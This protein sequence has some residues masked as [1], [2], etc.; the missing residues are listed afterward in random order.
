MSGT[1]LITIADLDRLIEEEADF[2]L[3][4]LAAMQ[5]RPAYKRAEADIM[6]QSSGHAEALKGSNITESITNVVGTAVVELQKHMFELQRLAISHPD[7]K[8][9]IL[10]QVNHTRKVANILTQALSMT[11]DID[12]K[13]TGKAVARSA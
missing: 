11:M 4:Q 12:K 1:H 2:P 5:L 6:N 10:N 3:A 7:Q 8:E 9:D 13:T